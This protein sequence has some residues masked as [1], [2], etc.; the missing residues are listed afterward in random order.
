MKSEYLFGM[1]EDFDLE[2]FQGENSL[3]SVTSFLITFR[4]TIEAALIIGILLTYVIKINKRKLRRDIWLGTISGIVLS[5]VVGVIFHFVLGNFEQY[6]EIIEGFSMIFA[7]VLL[8]WM[9]IWMTETG[10]DMRNNLESKIE[11]SI[12]NQQRLGLIFLA[13]ISVLREGIETVI[14]LAGVEAVEESQTTVLW[15]GL[16]GIAVA[17]MISVFL[18]FSGKKINLRLFF[19]ITSILLILFASGMLAHGFHELQEIGWFGQESAFM[20]QQVW[21][22]SFILN[23]KTTELGKFLRTMFGYQDKP[24]WLE[25]FVYIAYYIILALLFAII[26]KRKKILENKRKIVVNHELS[27][28]D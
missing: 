13:F 8:T 11:Y 15:S 9:I 20:Q 26:R 3:F 10:R 18:F 14:F 7:A 21:D 12:R 23:D 27:T 19:G 22:T 6:E 2:S 4:E 24:T 16:V 25:F 1:F 17:L 28:A 5:I